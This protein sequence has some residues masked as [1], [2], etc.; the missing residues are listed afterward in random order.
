M[1]FL[2]EI[3]AEC[4]WTA[5]EWGVVWLKVLPVAVVTLDSR[6]LAV[7]SPERRSAHV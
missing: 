2:H 1:S 3:N 4:A 7:S 6:L 5:I